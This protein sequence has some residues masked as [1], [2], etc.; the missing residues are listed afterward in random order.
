MRI[1]QKRVA[2]PGDPWGVKQHHWY[3][4]A[5]ENNQ[6]NPNE[7]SNRKK[8][9]ARFKALNPVILERWPHKV[10]PLRVFLK[11]INVSPSPFDC[12]ALDIDVIYIIIYCTEI[13]HVVNCGNYL[14]APSEI[15]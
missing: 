10:L 11:S 6:L 15:S 8:K 5:K 12:E 3:T 2:T 13:E 4:G 14:S 9:Q 1:W 7:A